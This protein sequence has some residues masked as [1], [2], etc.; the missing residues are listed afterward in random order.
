M[1]DNCTYHVVGVGDGGK[2]ETVRGERHAPDPP[3][4]GGETEKFVVAPVVVDEYLA[5]IGSGGLQR[6]NIN[7]Q[8]FSVLD[9]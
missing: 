6:K 2:S 9:K 1:L 3:S 4:V 8:L 5:I 7:L